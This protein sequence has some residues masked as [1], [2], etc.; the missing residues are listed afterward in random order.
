[1]TLSPQIV[2]LFQQAAITKGI[3]TNSLSTTDT[4]GAPSRRLAWMGFASDTPRLRP[5]WV[6][7]TSAM[8]SRMNAPIHLRCLLARSGKLVILSCH[9]LEAV[10][11]LTTISSAFI[12]VGMASLR[13][14]EH[15]CAHRSNCAR[16]SV[17]CL[18]P[19]SSMMP[20]ILP[21]PVTLRG[22]D[23][24]SRIRARRPPFRDRCISCHRRQASPRMSGPPGC[25]QGNPLRPSGLGPVKRQL[26]QLSS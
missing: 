18:L 3:G 2:V 14:V 22:A 9:Q 20:P 26:L 11:C 1:M 8:P 4:T 25:V 21:L 15:I 17:L 16:S 13:A 23:R 6:D 7:I 19:P 5:T 10:C 24:F 12:L